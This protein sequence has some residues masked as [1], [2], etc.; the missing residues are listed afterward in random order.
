[1]TPLFVCQHGLSFFVVG[2][3]KTEINFLFHF[4]STHCAIVLNCNLGGCLAVRNK[5]WVRWFIKLCKYSGLLCIFLLLC[6]SDKNAIS[7][8]LQEF[9]RRKSFQRMQNTAAQGNVKVFL[10]LSTLTSLRVP[11]SYAEILLFL[12]KRSLFNEACMNFR[13]RFRY[14]DKP[15]IFFPPNC[16]YEKTW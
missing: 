1:M 9:E 3:C 11:L 4:S 10:L 2:L 16:L 6:G 14:S 12:L 13:Q 15:W 7:V 8:K 5:N